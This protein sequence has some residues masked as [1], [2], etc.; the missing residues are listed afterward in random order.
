LTP[1]QRQRLGPTRSVSANA[2]ELYLKGRYYLNQRSPGAV[3][4]ARDLAERSVVARAYFILNS[5]TPT[6]RIPS[7][8][9]DADRWKTRIWRSDPVVGGV[10]RVVQ[11]RVEGDEFNVRRGC[12]IVVSLALVVF[13]SGAASAQT[14]VAPPPSLGTAE[15]PPSLGAVVREIP[16][17]LWKFLSWDTAVVLGIGGGAAL[18]G[19]TWDDDLA[20]E[21]ETNV[22]LNDAM[23]P[24]HTYG[25]FS[26]QALIGVA[27]YTGGRVGGR[28]GLARTGADIMRAQILS[29]AYVQAIKYTARRERPDGS[30][31]QSFPSGHSASAF[32]TATVLQ[33]HYGWKIG[34]P[35]TVVAAY[36]ATARVHDNKHYLS[37]V[38]FGGAMGVAAQRTVMLHAG[39]YGVSMVPTAVPGGGSMTMIVRTR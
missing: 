23:Q 1:A 20:G 22:R 30:N 5:L 11:W 19:H 39:R 36:V 38:I 9:P 29:Q 10:E 7:G 16:R 17:D 15:P 35:A 2:Y 13:V 14:V 28:G 24:G 33:R 26:V 4:K 32:A 8:R 21:V 31:T 18:I 27:L 3:E 12:R 6:T 37:D 25:A 34:V